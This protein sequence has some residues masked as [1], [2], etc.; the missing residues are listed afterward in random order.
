M[1]ILIPLIS[2]SFQLLQVPTTDDDTTES[3]M[4]TSDIDPDMFP[5]VV[6]VSVRTISCL[7]PILP[8]RN[9]KEKAVR[10]QAFAATVGKIALV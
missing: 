2:V 3:E 10:D 6:P 4:D 5:I 9:G 7:P 1:M 8:G